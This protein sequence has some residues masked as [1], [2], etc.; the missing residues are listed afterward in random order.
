MSDLFE[1]KPTSRLTFPLTDFMIA[2][3]KM[4]PEQRRNA[5]AKR[6]AERYGIRED[7]AQFEIEQ[8]RLCPEVWPIIGGKNDRRKTNR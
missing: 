1:S 3:Y 8:A 4:T 5:S 6:A 2:L 7:W